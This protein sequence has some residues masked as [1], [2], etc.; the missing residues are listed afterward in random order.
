MKLGKELEGCYEALK[1]IKRY[2]RIW[3]MGGN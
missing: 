2:N 3:C 1:Q